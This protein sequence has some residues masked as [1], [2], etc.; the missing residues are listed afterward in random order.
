MI[1][2]NGIAFGG[3]GPVMS[4]TWINPSTGHKFTVRDC[5][6][7]DGQF[8]VQTTSGQMLD[9]NT[10]QNYVQ[11][12]DAQ[13]KEVAV[14]TDMVQPKTTKPQIPA[15]VASLIEG[16]HESEYMIP[17]DTHIGLGNVHS[18]SQAA[19]NTA[20][21]GGHRGPVGAKGL[22][23][24][25]PDQLMIARVLRKHPSPDIESNIIWEVPERQIDTL[26]NVLGVD[27]DAV[28]EYYTNMLDP[29]TIMEHI[30]KT[31]TKHIEMI[32]RGGAPQLIVETTEP[33]VQSEQ[34]ISQEPDT[35]GA[36]KKAR[37]IKASPKKKKK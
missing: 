34:P 27:S 6:F 20:A 19:L 33:E 17:E 1:Q 32:A 7:Q 3:D 30:K 21:E 16:P 4:G 9:Y 8:M 13:G 14:P 35:Q 37:P 26:I 25:D 18:R 29:E 2:S 31:L 15:E 24:G 12:T 5:F 22:D 28:A 10:V 36:L 11:C 23:G